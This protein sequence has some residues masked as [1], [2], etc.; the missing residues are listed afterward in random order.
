[1]FM[2]VKVDKAIEFKELIPMSWQKET[3]NTM[4]VEMITYLLVGS[5]RQPS[6]SKTGPGDSK[7]S[8]STI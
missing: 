8:W 6:G 1:M 5:C 4:T 3:L 7:G 2:G